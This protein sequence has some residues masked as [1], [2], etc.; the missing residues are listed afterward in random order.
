MKTSSKFFSRFLSHPVTRILLSIL[1]CALVVLLVKALLVRPLIDSL[2][3][4]EYVKI[5]LNT[6]ILSIVLLLTY[7]FWFAYYEKREVSELN[8]KFLLKDGIGGFL[9]GAL[10]ISFVIVILYIIGNYRV[11]SVNE[12]S[13]LLFPLVLFTALSVVEEVIFRGILFRITEERLG[14][15]PALV[16]SSLIFGLIHI[17]NDFASVYSSLAIA[18]ELGLLTGIVYSITRRLWFP[19]FLHMGWNFSIAFYGTS[20]SGFQEVPGFLESEVHGSL[21]LTGG[22]F[23]P[24]NSL[25]TIVVSVILFL[26]IY[27]FGSRRGKFIKEGIEDCQQTE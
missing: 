1:I 13:V 27:R 16:I 11:L 26:V 8:M 21:F 5:S 19:I 6:F 25:I 17:S 3:V 14:T 4:E 23:G 9:S 20:V 2:G 18:L 24:E 15:I 10:I 12:F 22:D 7:R